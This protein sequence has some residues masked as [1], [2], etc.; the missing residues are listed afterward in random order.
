MHDGLDWAAII[1]LPCMRSP[2]RRLQFNH[3]MMVGL[4]VC[5]VCWNLALPT[6]LTGATR[7]DLLSLGNERAAYH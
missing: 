2:G 3:E 6:P 4:G 5:I 7:W 1:V